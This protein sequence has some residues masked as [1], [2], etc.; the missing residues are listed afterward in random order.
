ME[1]TM[2]GNNQAPIKMTVLCVDD[3]ANILKAMRRLLHKCDFELLLAESGPKALEIMAQQRVDLVVSDMKMPHMSGAEFLQQVAAEYPDTYRIILTGYADTQSTVAAVNKGKIHRYLQ[4]PWDNQELIGAIAEGLDRVKL[5]YDNQQLQK[6]IQAQNKLLKELNH[7]LEDKV[8]LRTK[9]IQ[10]ALQQMEKNNRATH[11]MLFNFISVN[12]NIDGGFARNVSD[13][14]KALAIKMGLK[15]AQVR[16]TTLAGLL[17][18]IGMLGIE[19]DLITRPFAELNFQEQQAFFMQTQT[20]L[21]MLAPATHLGNEN[22]MLFQ[23][24][25]QIDGKGPHQLAGEDIPL[26]ARIICIARDYWRYVSGRYLSDSLSSEEAIAELT[27]YRG[28]RYD[29]TILDLLIGDPGLATGDKRDKTLNISELSPGMTLKYNLFN[30]A[31][32]LLL[33]EG[34]ILT[35][36]SINK[37]KQFE[38][39]QEQS[40]QIAVS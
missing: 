36:E 3:E 35:K 5:K 26:G 25:E 4:K 31:H 7:N 13:L 16:E 33:P 24:F 2:S 28:T 27:K 30:D 1:T 10:L 6:V 18:E 40:L 34:H 14:T 32:I 19:A 8:K 37:L 21:M 11:R 17:C 39:T 38:A 15:A 12:P 9:Q 23:Q 20:S 29:A 22:E